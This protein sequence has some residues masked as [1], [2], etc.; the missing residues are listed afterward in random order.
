MSTYQFLLNLQPFSTFKTF[1]LSP[2]PACVC[3]FV[4]LSQPGPV[5]VFVCPC[6]P[7]FWNPGKASRVPKCYRSCSGSLGLN[8]IGY[9]L[10]L[11]QVSRASSLGSPGLALGCSRPLAWSGHPALAGLDARQRAG[12]ISSSRPL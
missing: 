5:C 9:R 6:P 3:V 7:G 11:W 1:S 12:D 8:T 10:Q 2:G 4:C